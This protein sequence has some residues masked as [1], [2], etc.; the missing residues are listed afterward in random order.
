MSASWS[1]SDWHAQCYRK[2]E[3]CGRV[4]LFGKRNIFPHSVR[5]RIARHPCVCILS[6]WSDLLAQLPRLSH[7]PESYNNFSHPAHL[8]LNPM[9]ISPQF[10]GNPPNRLYKYYINNTPRWRARDS[11]ISKTTGE[12]SSGTPHAKANGRMEN[13]PG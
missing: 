7:T 2:R 4:V 12:T 9:S 3:T 11:R 5:T 13:V 10:S 1:G 8:P 6:F